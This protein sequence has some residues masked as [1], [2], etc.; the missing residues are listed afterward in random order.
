M[1]TD[2]PADGDRMTAAHHAGSVDHGDGVPLTPLARFIDR[3]R[4]NSA[5]IRALVHGVSAEQALW[6][7]DPAHWSIV[8]VI[9]HL[10]DEEKEDFRVRIDYTLHRYGEAW[11]PIDPTGWVSERRYA[12]RS[13]QESLDRFLHNRADSISWLSGLEAPDWSLGVDR[14]NGGRLT[15]GD[16][17][18][19]WVA[20]DFNH[21]RQLN[22]LHRA[23]FLERVAPFAGDYAGPW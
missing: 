20:H 5:I 6:R 14:P 3:L 22:R 13:L 1:S 2:L 11:P 12:E 4:A 9:N 15:A 10:A 7:P 21:I 18:A 19:S 16:L 8:E 23:Y 17:L